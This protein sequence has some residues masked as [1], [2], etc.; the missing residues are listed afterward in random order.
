MIGN[1]ISR[2]LYGKYF[3]PFLLQPVNQSRR[4]LNPLPGNIFFRTQRHLHKLLH[5][6]AEAIYG[7][8]R[9]AAKVNFFHPDRVRRSEYRADIVNTADAIEN[10]F[11][12]SN[13]INFLTS[14]AIANS[15]SG[16]KTNDFAYF[17]QDK[18]FK[19]ALR[20]TGSPAPIA[21]VKQMASSFFTSAAYA[22]MYLRT[23]RTKTLNA[24]IARSSFAALS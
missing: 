16:S 13:Y 1:G 17:T 4:I 5:R 24:K 11:H 21:P 23:R 3:L 10:H 7:S 8:R 15:S 20:V 6:P 14:F 19:I 18:S 12:T 9:H 2:L 22:P